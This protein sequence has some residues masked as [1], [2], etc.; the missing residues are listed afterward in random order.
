MTTE[1]MSYFIEVAKCLSFSEAAD[2]LYI[3]QSSLSRQIIALEAELGVT[4]FVRSRNT[5]KLTPEG[6]TFYSKIVDILE[7]VLRLVNDVR[8]YGTQSNAILSIG[9][10]EDQILHPALRK[11][12]EFFFSSFPNIKVRMFGRP[13]RAMSDLLSNMEIDLLISPSLNSQSREPLCSKVF[14]RDQ[15]VLLAPKSHP[16]AA[17][18]TIDPGDMGKYFGDSVMGVLRSIERADFGD[19]F[20]LAEHGYTPRIVSCATP[21]DLAM[22]VSSGFGITITNSLN[23]LAYDPNVSV[24]HIGSGTSDANLLYLT[25]EY[26]TKNQNPNIR[27]FLEVLDQFAELET[28]H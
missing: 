22:L 20:C 1:Q 25:A 7:N 5:V 8:C 11:T 19:R 23:V 27:L 13:Y 16:H 24:I 10:S 9:V 18:G 12:L 2:H 15:F 14:A 21:R 6:A 3:S 4:L 26:N 17:I 28:I